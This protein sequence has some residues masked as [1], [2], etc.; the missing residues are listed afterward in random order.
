MRRPYSPGVKWWHAVFFLTTTLI[1]ATDQLSKLWIRY[2]LPVGESSFEISFFGIVHTT[3]T[4]AA[5]G[6]FRGQSF[7]LTIVA[8]VG[9]VVI[10]LGVLLIY[11]HFPHLNR[12]LSIVALGL[13]LGGTIGNLIDRIYLGY[14]TDFISIGIWPNFNVADSAVVVG[15]FMFAFSLYPVLRTVKD[16]ADKAAS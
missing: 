13:V 10:L 7:A 12:W 1:V 2:N 5:F 8:A 9:I 14:V 6:L 15:V 4:G 16:N 11:R 3:N